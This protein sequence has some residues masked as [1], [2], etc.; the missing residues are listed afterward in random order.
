MNLNPSSKFLLLLGAPGRSREVPPC[1]VHVLLCRPLKEII[2]QRQAL[3]IRAGLFWVSSC[4][5][6]GFQNSCLD[7]YFFSWE[8]REKS[9]ACIPTV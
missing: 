3:R 9:L 8:R 5:F 4:E 7:I 1:E 6:S 2:D